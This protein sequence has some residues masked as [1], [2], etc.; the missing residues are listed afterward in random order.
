MR[1][2]LSPAAWPAKMGPEA[3]AELRRFKPYALIP[4]P[5]A[6]ARNPAPGGSGQP[7]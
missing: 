6:E 7:T 5:E 1:Y 4:E 3:G 2:A